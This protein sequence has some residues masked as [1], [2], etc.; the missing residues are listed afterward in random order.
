MTAMRPC[1]L[2]SASGQASVELL[3]LLPLLALVGLGIL[4]VLAAGAA[5]EVADA[6]AE[7]GAVA[8]LQERDPRRA[9]RESLP[10]WSRDQSSVTVRGRRVRVEVRPRG[11]IDA[12]TRRLVAAASADAGPEPGS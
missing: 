4:Q 9:A 2:R 6:A 11:P 7:A 12:L 10:G 1:A 5:H 8:M 3:A